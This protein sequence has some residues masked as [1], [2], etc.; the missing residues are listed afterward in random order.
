MLEKKRSVK[1]SLGNA[2]KPHRKCSK[3][4]GK[5]SKNALNAS[6]RALL[7]GFIESTGRGVEPMANSKEKDKKRTRWNFKEEAE[8]YMRKNTFTVMF[9]CDVSAFKYTSHL[10]QRDFSCRDQEMIILAFLKKY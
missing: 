2:L 6:T 7:H 9:H 3:K 10:S 5:C 1:K 4:F 8:K